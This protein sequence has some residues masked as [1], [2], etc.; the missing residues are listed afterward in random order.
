MLFAPKIILVEGIAEQLL[1]SVFAQ[2][3]NLSLED[4]HVSV[5]NI[6]CRYFDHFLKIFNNNNDY[7]IDRKVACI[8]D[9]D[10]ARKKK[11]TPNAR[12][13]ACYPFEYNFDD[14]NYVYSFNKIDT[15]IYNGSPNIKFFQPDKYQL[16]SK[17]VFITKTL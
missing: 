2:Y 7:A 6:G 15:E 8:T 4:Q 10:P 16:K 17:H 3:I 9:F 11:N 14:E 12:A 13:N 5:I 1:L